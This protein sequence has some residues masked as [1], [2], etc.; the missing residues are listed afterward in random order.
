MSVRA[1]SR[2]SVFQL[3]LPNRSSIGRGAHRLAFVSV[4]HFETRR[5][6]KSDQT[7]SGGVVGE[8]RMGPGGLCDAGDDLGLAVGEWSSPAGCRC[9]NQRRTRPERSRPSRR[10]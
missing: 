6:V 9:G 10:L 1:V 2:G 5:Q 4:G 8:E 3:H 7:T